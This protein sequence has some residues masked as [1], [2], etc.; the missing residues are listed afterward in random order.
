MFQSDRI[1]L[2]SW[3]ICIFVKNISNKILLTC[4]G[5]HKKV[6]LVW[7]WAA[8]LRSRNG[9]DEFFTMNRTL[10][11]SLHI[12]KVYLESFTKH[13]N[14]IFYYVFLEVINFWSKHFSRKYI[15]FSEE[16][17]LIIALVHFVYICKNLS[18]NMNNQ[19]YRYI[20]VVLTVM[21]TIEFAQM[22]R[23]TVFYLKFI[24]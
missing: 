11:F 23:Y 5:K 8:L 6:P 21:H 18:I 22:Y 2:I 17:S 24:Y 4:R 7:P 9:H 19:I 20:Y 3:K 16:I 15:Y 1:S 10:H 12:L 13:Y 14:K